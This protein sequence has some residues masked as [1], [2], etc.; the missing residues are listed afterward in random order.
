MAGDWIPVEDTLSQKCEILIVASATGMSRYEVV[1]RLVEFWSW[2]QNVAHTRLLARLTLRDI[3]AALAQPIEFFHAV[4]DAGWLRETEEGVELVNAD[5]WIEDG[6]KARL[7]KAKRQKRYRDGKQ[8]RGADVDAR[9]DADVDGGA[10]TCASTR[11]EKSREENKK[12]P[13]APLGG[14][15][16]PASLSQSGEFAQ[17]WTDWVGYRRKRRKPLVDDT[18][19]AQLAKLADWGVSKAIRSIRRSIEQGWAGLFDPD[20]DEHG[21]GRSPPQPTPLVANRVLSPEETRALMAGQ[22]T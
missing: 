6:S 8:S 10:P 14:F 7:L 16:I 3:S 19:N 13:I 5:W 12:P 18:A 15:E 20:A 9:V 11:V 2:A 1:G 17:A 21:G 4:R 22:R